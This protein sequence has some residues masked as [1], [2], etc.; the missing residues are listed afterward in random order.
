M[1]WIAQKTSHVSL[2]Y[3]F[4]MFL[5]PS[6]RNP[7][8]GVYAWYHL[9]EM[10]FEHTIKALKKNSLYIEGGL[11]YWHLGKGER[12]LVVKFFTPECIKQSSGSFIKVKAATG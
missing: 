2:L 6:P 4:P 7:H 9:R 5:T 11:I 10:Q 3:I 1:T 12:A 8:E